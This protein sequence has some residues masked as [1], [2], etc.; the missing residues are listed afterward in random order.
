MT[1]AN[2]YTRALYDM[3]D[4]SDWVEENWGTIRRA[5]RIARLLES[6]PSKSIVSEGVEIRQIGGGCTDI[7]KAMAAELIKQAEE[8]KDD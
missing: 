2:E 5:L 1:R 6:E 8:S 4:S 3:R 7:F